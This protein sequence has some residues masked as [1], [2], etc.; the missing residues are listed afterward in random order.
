MSADIQLWDPIKSKRF[1]ANLQDFFGYM[2][3]SNYIEIRP[4]VFRNMC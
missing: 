1:S 3:Y 4:T 2:E